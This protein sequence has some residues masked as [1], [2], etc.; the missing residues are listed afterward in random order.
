MFEKKQT[1]LVPV[2]FTRDPFSVLRHMTSSLERAFDDWPSF[3]VPS[4]ADLQIGEPSAWSPKIDVFERDNRLVTRIDLPGI[5]KED[6]TVEV[7]DGHL[8]LSG[9]RKRETEEKK[10]NIYRTEREYGRF[11]RL[12]P[13]P[14]GITPEDVKA[15]FADGV[16]EVSVPLPARPASN[17]RKVQIEEPKPSAKSA[18]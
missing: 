13:L 18:A 4:F 3:R 6:V 16:L 17:V 2:R 15:T 14:E 8:A 12:V 9:E 1:P 10:D 5:K 11:Y 7:T